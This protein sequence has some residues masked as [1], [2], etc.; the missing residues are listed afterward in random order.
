MRG[1]NEPAWLRVDDH[2]APRASRVQLGVADQDSIR[3]RRSCVFGL[4]L[5]PTNGV[6]ILQDQRERIAAF[7][8]SSAELGNPAGIELPRQLLRQ[9]RLSRRL[10][11]DYRD[12][13]DQPWAH[14]RRH[15]L[16]VREW[17]GA[18]RG[19]GYRHVRS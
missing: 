7:A 16:P 1:L 12:A 4:E 13:P 9:R 11:A 8:I 18:D 3:M 19:A 15:E 2:L 17:V 14:N 10:G 6:E 5:S